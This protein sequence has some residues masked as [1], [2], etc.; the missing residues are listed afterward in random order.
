[1][2]FDDG[3]Q[4]GS[5]GEHDHPTVRVAIRDWL[6]LGGLLRKGAP[7]A[8][9]RVADIGCGYRAESSRRLRKDASSTVLVDLSVAPVLKEDE[10]VEVIE[11]ALPEA[12]SLIPDRSIDVLLCSAVLEHLVEPIETLRHFPRVLSSA[13]V[14]LISVPSWTAKRPL[15]FA[16]FR[17]GMSTD[18]MND[19]KMYYNPRDLWPLLIKAGFRP[20]DVRCHKHW[21]R[22]NTLAVCRQRPE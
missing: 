4:F 21:L 9:R 16:A 7:S 22:V 13:G 17:L 8:G 1:M 6:V 11:A 20:Q 2:T 12:M 19:H 10:R 14:A 18:E 3:R 15:E 5:Y